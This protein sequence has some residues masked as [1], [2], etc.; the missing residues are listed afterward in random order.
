MSRGGRLGCPEL[1]RLAAFDLDG[2]LV[3]DRTCVESIARRSSFSATRITHLGSVV[4]AICALATACRGSGSSR[5][6]PIEIRG[7]SLVL[8]DETS[9]NVIADVGVGRDPSRVVY[10]HGAFWVVS[11]EAG[12][13]VRVDADSKAATRFH[14]GEDPY[15]VAI[16]GGALWGPDHDEQRLLRVDRDS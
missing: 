16:G 3:H 13:V 9:D 10:G 7:N 2:T 8:I 5:A 15:D 1:I 4:L 6:E 11:H 12:V 14:I